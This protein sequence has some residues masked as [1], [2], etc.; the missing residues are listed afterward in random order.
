MGFFGKS[1]LSD[2]EISRAPPSPD[3]EKKIPSHEE[4]PSRPSN[5]TAAAIDPELERRVLRKLDLRLPT[6]MG[7]F[8][9]HISLNV[10]VERL[11]EKKN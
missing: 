3:V 7:F 5:L 8:C 6:I 11:K 9:A 4:R 1:D 10:P 2:D